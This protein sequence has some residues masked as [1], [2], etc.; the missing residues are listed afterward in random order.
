[1][2]PRDAPGVALV[3]LRFSVA[4]MLWIDEPLASA[5]LARQWVFLGFIL[6]TIALCVG[7][8]TPAV[9]VLCVLFKGISLLYAE[10]VQPFLTIVSISNALAL[11]LL[12]PGAYS[13]DAWLFGRQVFIV[14]PGKEPDTR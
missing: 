5:H 13:I 12:G 6:V 11:A 8:L 4:V 10:H 14:S 7:I 2:F 1:M 9:A 3:L